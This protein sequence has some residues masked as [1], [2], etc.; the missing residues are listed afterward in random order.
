MYDNGSSDDEMLGIAQDKLMS[1]YDL[2]ASE[3]DMSF[4][5]LMS[6]QTKKAKCIMRHN[7]VIYHLW[8]GFIAVL[9]MVSAAVTPLEMAF[10]PN[11]SKIGFWVLDS[12]F[13]LDILL[14]FF[15]TLP[16]YGA[17]GTT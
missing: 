9:P 7:S 16:R 11:S 14:T 15:V 12:F 3:L 2:S 13:I 1:A 17:R 6:P 4:G 5:E 8:W 10:F